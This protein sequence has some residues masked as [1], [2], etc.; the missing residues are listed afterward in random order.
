MIRIGAIVGYT[1][2]T[3]FFA[4]PDAL[5][6]R[7]METAQLDG[8]DRLAALGTDSGGTPL[9]WVHGGSVPIGVRMLADTL[10][11]KYQ[12]SDA[13]VTGVIRDNAPAWYSQLASR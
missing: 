7:I 6:R 1:P 5:A 3:I 9:A 11:D 2:A 8:G 4:D 12:A 10:S 13:L